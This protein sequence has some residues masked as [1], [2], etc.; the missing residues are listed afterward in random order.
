MATLMANGM[1]RR[2]E[3]DADGWRFLGVL[4]CH[5]CVAGAPQ[6]LSARAFVDAFAAALVISTYTRSFKQRAI[7]RPIEVL[8]TCDA[9]DPVV[10]F[11]GL[12]RLCKKLPNRQRRVVV[13]HGT[14]SNPLN[15][16]TRFPFWPISHE[17]RPCISPA[18]HSGR[19]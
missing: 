11:R 12:L 6:T 15:P 14:L 17:L 10:A 18:V 7:D 16:R 3:A 4:G 8:R 9:A 13:S 5:Y 2:P 1:Q 19:P